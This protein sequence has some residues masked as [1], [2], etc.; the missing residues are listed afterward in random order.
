MTEVEVF[1][2]TTGLSEW[3]TADRSILM[4]PSAH[5]MPDGGIFHTGPQQNTYVL[6]PTTQAWD[7]IDA[8]NFGWRGTG[9]GD[10]HSVMLP[11]ATTRS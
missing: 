7:F 8:N 4:Y 11:P 6:N 9:T 1:N 10:F 2:P 5:L 3:P